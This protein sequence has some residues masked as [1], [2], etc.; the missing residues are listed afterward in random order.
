MYVCFFQEN[1]SKTKSIKTIFNKNENAC[2]IDCYELN[3]EAKSKI[4][5]NFI[6][7]NNIV[8]SREIYWELLEKLDN[9]YGLLEKTLNN[10]INLQKNDIKIENINKIL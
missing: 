1:S 2:L 7:D 10:F 3:K 6:K 9:R 8:V 4:L 5:N